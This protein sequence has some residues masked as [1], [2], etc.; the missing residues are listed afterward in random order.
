MT[1]ISER[2]TSGGLRGRRWPRLLGSVL[3][4][5]LVAVLA[6]FIWPSNLGGGTTAIVVN[7]HSMEPTYYTGDIVVARS[8]EPQVGDVVVYTTADLGEAKIIHR[9]IGGDGE[10]GWEI[11][12]DNN[13]FVDPYHPTNDDVLGI[14]LV[15][16][17]AVGTFATVLQNPFV[18]GSFLLLGL[19]LVIW[20]SKPCPEPECDGDHTTVAGSD[21]DDARSAA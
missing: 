12:G 19:G 17:P 4:W 9:I 8:G 15:H 1:A 2:R 11:Q 14:A 20:P 16:V 6:Y 18:W 5:G 10:S 21:E 13:D 7:G 3:A